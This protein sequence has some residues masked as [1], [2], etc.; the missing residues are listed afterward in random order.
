MRD[1]RDI[2]IAMGARTMAKILNIHI[3]KYNDQAWSNIF[4]YL[5]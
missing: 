3:I 4:K 2:L 5:E 1:N